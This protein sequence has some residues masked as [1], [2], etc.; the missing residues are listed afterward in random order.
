MK[1]KPQLLKIN[2]DLN[3]LNAFGKIE[4]VLFFRKKHSLYRSLLARP[5]LN[6]CYIELHS[7]LHQKALNIRKAK[8][9]S[10]TCLKLGGVDSGKHMLGTFQSSKL[11]HILCSVILYFGEQDWL[12]G[13]SRSK[14]FPYPTYNG[15]QT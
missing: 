13:V 8:A 12:D 3:C 4:G 15:E 9:K 2:T 11:T 1:T 7:S 5:S 14:Y 6:D 10:F